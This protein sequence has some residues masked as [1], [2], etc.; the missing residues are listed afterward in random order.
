[1][2]ALLKQ[3]QALPPEERARITEITEIQDLLIDR[4]VE[5]REATEKGQAWRAKELEAEI[6]EL[7]NEKGN[8]AQWAAVGSA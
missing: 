6:E 2:E 7:K 3:G 5:H 8:V 4:F 1:M